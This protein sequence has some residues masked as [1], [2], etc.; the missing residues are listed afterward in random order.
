ML[1]AL[2]STE[3][4]L[5]DLSKDIGETN[6]LA[7]SYPEIVAELLAKLDAFKKAI[8]QDPENLQALFNIGVVQ[9]HDLKDEDG[10][11]KTWEKVA[12][13]KPDFQLSTGQTLEQLLDKLK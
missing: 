5:F 11:K 12:K 10:A 2:E 6:N 3:P 1:P 7:E 4:M 9:Y 13:V 8:A